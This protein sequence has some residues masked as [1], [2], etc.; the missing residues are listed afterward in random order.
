[1]SFKTVVCDVCGQ[2]VSKKKTLAIGEGKRACRTHEGTTSA[3]KAQQVARKAKE[4][5][6]R[7]RWKKKSRP[8]IPDLNLTPKCASCG[9]EGIRQ[10]EFFFAML[11]AGEKYELTYGKPLNPF[12]PVEAKKAYSEIKG[13]CLWYVEYDSKK[14]TLPSVIRPVAAM[15]GWVMLCNKCCDQFGIDPNPVASDLSLEQ[16]TSVGIAYDAFVR[17]SIQK[18]AMKQLREVN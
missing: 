2:E 3:A 8:Q 1:M 11:L 14:I 16:L 15:L 4:Q 10:Q 5:A 17:P 12:D 6:A 9:Q 7:D 13:V 18:E